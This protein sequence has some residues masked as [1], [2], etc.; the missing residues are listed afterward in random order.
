M[1]IEKLEKIQQKQ[2]DL[3]KQYEKSISEDEKEELRKQIFQLC[4]MY[5]KLANDENL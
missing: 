1:V 5:V 4:N 3:I 2:R